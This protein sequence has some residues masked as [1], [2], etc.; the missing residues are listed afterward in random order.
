MSLPG[1]VLPHVLYNAAAVR[2]LDRIAIEDEGIAGLTLMERAGKASFDVLREL[3][4]AAQRLTVICGSGNNGG[5]GYVLARIAHQAGLAVELVN[6][7]MARGGAGDAGLAAEKAAAAGI[8]AVEYRPELLDE[9]DVVV[10]ALLGTGLDRSLD[11]QWQQLIEEINSR[12][13]AILAI[14]IA[15]GLHADT[16]AAMPVAVRADATVTFIGLKQGLFTGRGRAYSGDI[17]FFDLE[18]PGHIYDRVALSAE[19]IDADTI[20]GSLK[21]RP[22][23]LHKGGC[24][25]VA[26]VGGDYGFAGAVRM[27]GE[28]AL[29]CGAGLVTVASRREHCLALPQGRPELMTRAVAGP[30]DLKPL[31]AGSDVVVAGP[32]MGQSEWA[33]GLLAAVLECRQPLVL[34]ADAL[35]LLA[36]EPLRV[37]QGVMT[38]HPGEAARLLS[39]SVDEINA[40]RFKAILEL[41]SRFGGVWILKGSGS[42]VFGGE[43]VPA[44]C[45]AGNPGMASGG[46]GDVLSGVIA[47][48]LAQGL[49]AVDAARAAVTMHSVAADRAALNGGERGLIATDLMLK[50]RELANS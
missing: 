19:R 44:L 40:D 50:L 13:S 1:P 20:A 5:D 9:A 6:C 4:P 33:C 46:M 17:I 32:G 15:S 21:T 35:N 38:P 31:L 47:A 39:C 27:A 2:E 49:E 14:D 26:V 45:S 36:R 18:V 48:L 42:L 41:Q 11:E 43:Q 12:A 10:D 25:H 7:G 37:E 16:G 28:A 22:R 34:D 3:W 30:E 23:D 8:R 24:G 29:R